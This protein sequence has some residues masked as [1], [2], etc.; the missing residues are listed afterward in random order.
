MK[1]FVHLISGRIVSK[2]L[3]ENEEVKPLIEIL[4]NNN[5]IVA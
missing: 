2:A 5:P 4:E 3:E 1:L